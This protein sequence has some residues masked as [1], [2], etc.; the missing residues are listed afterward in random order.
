MGIATGID[1]GKLLALRAQVAEMARRRDA[2]WL[3]LAGRPA[4][5]LRRPP[6][7]PLPP[8]QPDEPIP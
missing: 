7:K 5:D 3:A 2:A 4:Q 1:I 8:D 6:P